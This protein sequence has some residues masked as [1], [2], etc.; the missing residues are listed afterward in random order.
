MRLSHRWSRAAARFDDENLVSCSGL[1]PVMA[2]AEQ[3]GLSD[4]V[5][6]AVKITDPPIASTGVNPAGKIASV[7]AGM[8]AGA[9]SIDDLDVIRHGGMKRLFDGVYAPSTLGSFLRAFTHGHALQ[10]AS[11]ARRLLVSLAERTPILD[12]ADALTFVD[13]DSL[14]RRVYGKKKQG[15]RFGHTKVG[16]YP[17]RLRGLSPLVA[18]LSTPIAAPVIAGMRLRSGSAGSGRGAASLLTQ[19]LTT[20]KA[21]GATGRLWVRADSAYYAGAVV[22]AACTAGAWFS[23]TVVNNAAIRAAIATID[24]D[25]WTPVEYPDAVQD[26][27]TGEWISDAEVAETTYTAFAG[28]QHEITARLIVRRVKD[29]N[30]ADALFPVW[31]H[32]AFLTNT[33]L[34]TVDADVTHRQHAIIETTFADLIDGPLAHLPSGCFN[35]NAAW[36]ICAA[37]THNLL[38]AAGCLTSRFHAKARGSTLRRHLITVPARLARPQGKPVLHLPAHWPWAQ[39]FTTLH[40]AASSPPTAA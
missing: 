12:G 38:R 9:D 3:A 6:D 4:L 31:R 16:G 33:T 26:P 23:I 18:T 39:H 30:H 10:L 22:T 2:L 19:A 34:S 37:I 1:V 21:A 32:H 20:A 13:I 5:S 17:V 15:A 25:A 7:I 29:K 8:A 27:D 28:T 14:L 40:A 36:A 24:A 11:A 35:A